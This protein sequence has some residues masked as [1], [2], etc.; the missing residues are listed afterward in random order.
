MLA[1]INKRRQIVSKTA[2]IAVGAIGLFIIGGL[3]NTS[4]R[5]LD[6]DLPEI[7]FLILFPLPL[8][9][10]GLYL[11]YGVV[12]NLWR[13]IDYKTICSVSTVTAFLL[14]CFLVV[15]FDKYFYNLDKSFE[16]IWLQVD[17]FVIVLLIGPFYLLLKKRFLCWL[18]IEDRLDYDEYKRGRKR[19]FGFLAFFLW[20]ALSDMTD[21]LPKKPGYDYVP[22]SDL[23][24]GVIV[25][26]SMAAAYLFYRICI[27]VFIKKPH[28]FAEAMAEHVEVIA[29]D[30]KD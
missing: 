24:L 30:E 22:S 28:E 3:W 19:Y 8:T 2:S 16:T 9:L 18:C 4:L 23:M 27:M 11:L 25:I 26:G 29:D 10:F 6:F 7:A 14:G 13:S 5:N 15:I 17:L 20:M 1:D 12:L 21:L